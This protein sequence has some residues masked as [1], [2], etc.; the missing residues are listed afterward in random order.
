MGLFD[1]FRRHSEPEGFGSPLPDLSQSLPPPSEF[2]PPS[3]AAP[4]PQHQYTPPVQF[5]PPQPSFDHPI[6]SVVPARQDHDKDFQIL[7]SKL[8]TITAELDGIKQR[9]MH[10]ERIAEQVPSKDRK[11]GW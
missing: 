2:N 9:V 5:A 6:A 3:F 10:I 11:Y 7:F 8:D 1:M 4:E